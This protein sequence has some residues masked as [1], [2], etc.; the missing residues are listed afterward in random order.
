MVAVVREIVRTTNPAENA[1]S[2]LVK[3]PNFDFFI[4]LTFPL[5][6]FAGSYTSRCNWWR[7]AV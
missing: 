2:I 3:I 4:D 7:T 1:I 6:G 5:V